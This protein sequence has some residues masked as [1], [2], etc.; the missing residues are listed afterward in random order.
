MKEYEEII[1]S[2]AYI[3]HNLEEVGVFYFQVLNEN[4]DDWNEEQTNAEYQ[5]WLSKLKI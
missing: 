4:G 2:I 1:K 5:N 3:T